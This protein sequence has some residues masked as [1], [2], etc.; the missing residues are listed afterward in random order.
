MELYHDTI[1]F[2]HHQYLAVYLWLSKGFKADAMIHLGT[3]STYEWT[4]GKL[5]SPAAWNLG[6]KAAQQIIGKYLIKNGSYPQKVAVILW[7]VETLAAQYAKSIIQKGI[8]CCDHTCNNPMLN[9]MVVS[10]ISIPGVLS[11]KL[12]AQCKLAVEQMAKQPL[13]KQAADR[14]ALLEK[15]AAPVQREPEPSSPE[16]SP[17]EK[18]G[19][20]NNS[21]VVEGYK[22]EKSNKKRT[23]PR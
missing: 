7:A 11:P 19:Q 12:I 2:P 8:A 13:E 18:S 23:P 22:M 10:I 20:Q 21:E 16:Q 5:P 9:Q 3:H 17:S 14:K 4:P 1:L 15:L 6:K